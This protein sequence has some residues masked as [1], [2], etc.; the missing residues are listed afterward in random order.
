MEKTYD[1][2]VVRRE[3]MNAIDR[4]PADYQYL[5]LRWIVRYG[6]DKQAPAFDTTDP[7]AAMAYGVVMSAMAYIDAD[8]EHRKSAGRKGGRPRVAEEVMPEEEK[9]Q[10]QE[11]EVESKETA[12]VQPVIPEPVEEPE[13]A[14]KA[15]EDDVPAYPTLDEVREYWEEE[16]L[17]GNPEKFYRYHSKTGWTIK[18]E[19]IESWQGC[20]HSWSN[21]ERNYSSKSTKKTN[22]VKPP[23]PIEFESEVEEDDQEIQY[24]VD[25]EDLLNGD[26]DDAD[27]PW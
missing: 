17:N 1:T 6:L 14:T 15:A 9:K 13:P 27:M 7:M 22:P 25:I 4:L 5:A 20:A 2:T 8:H 21:R 3:W 24:A 12:P 16:G 26:V 18:G 11:Q 23:E 19:P 10:V